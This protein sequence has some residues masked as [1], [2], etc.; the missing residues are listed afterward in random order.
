MPY[1][2][3]ITKENLPDTKC[4]GVYYLRY[5]P[6]RKFASVSRAN[7]EDKK[8]T[9][10]IGKSQNLRERLWALYR[11]IFEPGLD[12]GHVAANRYIRSRALLTAFPPSSLWLEWNITENCDE[13]EK[14]RQKAYMDKYGELP[15][16][17]YGA[18]YDSLAKEMGDP[19]YKG[20]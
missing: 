11:V 7:G 13:E 16:L 6:N 2:S 5:K 18:P 8:G 9:I 10:Y 3:K 12:R 14:I 19:K 1:L 17:N 4:P 20:C 15:P